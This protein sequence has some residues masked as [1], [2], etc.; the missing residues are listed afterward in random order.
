MKLVLAEEVIMFSR[1]HTNLSMWVLL[2]SVVISTL[3]ESC[4]LM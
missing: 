2:G 3:L 1:G 4:A